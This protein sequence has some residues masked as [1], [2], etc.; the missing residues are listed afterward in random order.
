M[1]FRSTANGV[2]TA[3]FDPVDA[4][5]DDAI[6][7]AIYP[8]SAAS[9]SQLE[10]T[11]LAVDFSALAG[12]KWMGAFNAD[13]EISSLPMAA[14]SDGEA[15]SFKNLCGGVRIQLTDYQL[16]GISIK[17][18]A[19]RGNDGEQVSGI[20]DVNAADGIVSLRKSS[21]PSAAATALVDRKSV[22]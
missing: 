20:A 9:A 5:V 22:V 19:V 1:L 17:S 2:R 7:Y 15:F 10:G 18:V 3:V 12:Q 14:A 21:T 8:A 4:S 16:M 11:T 6:R 13:S